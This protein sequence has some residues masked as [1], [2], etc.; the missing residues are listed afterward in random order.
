MK[1]LFIL[2]ILLTLSAC[3]STKELPPPEINC[4]QP[5]VNEPIDGGLGGTG[6]LPNE[7]CPPSTL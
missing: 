4:S 1:K 6:A 7:S 2:I 3:A 5:Q